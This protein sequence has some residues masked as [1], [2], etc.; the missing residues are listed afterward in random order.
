[1]E[2]HDDV[3]VGAQS[4]VPVRGGFLRAGWV[5]VETCVRF[6]NSLLEDLRGGL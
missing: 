1:M 2:K 5:G 4:C 3:F 6:G